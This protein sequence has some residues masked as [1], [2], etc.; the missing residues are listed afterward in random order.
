MSI[1][2][3][4]CL[5]YSLLA[6]V[7]G[8]VTK[9]CPKVKCLTSLRLSFL[10]WIVNYVIT[11]LNL[12]YSLWR[13]S[14]I[15]SYWHP[16]SSRRIISTPSVCW[17]RRSSRQRSHE[18]QTGWSVSFRWASRGGGFGIPLRRVTQISLMV[19]WGDSYKCSTV[20]LTADTNLSLPF[21]TFVTSAFA[22]L[23]SFLIRELVGVL[24]IFEFIHLT[25]DF[26]LGKN[27][28]PN[29]HLKNTDI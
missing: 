27:W 9:A 24:L 2:W 18:W 28:A 7:L 13:R 23:P 1:L 25:I 15:Y 6:Q 17:T 11:V 26:R 29:L 14:R 10:K 4:C 8:E 16:T 22:R 19:V 20:T 12:L 3:F 5:I 21:W